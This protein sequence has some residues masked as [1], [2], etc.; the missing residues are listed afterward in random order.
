MTGSPHQ[1]DQ[2]DHGHD[3]HRHADTTE[4]HMDDAGDDEYRTV[5]DALHEMERPHGEEHMSLAEAEA[6]RGDG[7]GPDESRQHDEDHDHGLVSLINRAPRTQRESVRT[8]A[9]IWSPT[10]SYISLA[11]AR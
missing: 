1:R 2:P 10:F 11:D 4:H 6:V 9:D 3:E 7:D 8:F 5:E